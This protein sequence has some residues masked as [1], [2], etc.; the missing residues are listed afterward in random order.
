MAEQNKEATS[1][2]RRREERALNE[3]AQDSVTR[4]T[5]L[6]AVGMEVMQKNIQWQSELA[7]YWADTL[8]VAHN[9]MS[10]IIQT[11]QQQRKHVA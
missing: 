3:L 11:T 10:Q 9:S 7:R 4:F 8:N 1:L 2:D 5:D 6:T